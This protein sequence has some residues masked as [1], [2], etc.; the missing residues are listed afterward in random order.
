MNT[1]VMSSLRGEVKEILISRKNRH[2]ICNQLARKDPNQGR[3]VCFFWGFIGHHN[4]QA[5]SLPFLS[6]WSILITS[7]NP[8]RGQTCYMHLACY[9]LG[10]YGPSFRM[11]ISVVYNGSGGARDS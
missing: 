3:F 11:V 7:Q 1:V 5:Y 9:F 4:L 8:Y 10:D 2:V 6:T